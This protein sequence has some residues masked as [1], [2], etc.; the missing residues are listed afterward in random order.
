[1]KLVNYYS[2]LRVA[3]SFF[4]FWLAFPDSEGVRLLP[5]LIIS[6]LYQVTLGHLQIL[7]VVRLT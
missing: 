2:D 7:D 3:Q 1:M 4:K 6:G 5:K